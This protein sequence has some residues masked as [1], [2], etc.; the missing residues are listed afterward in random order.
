[1]GK[2]AK[3]IAIVGISRPARPRLIGVIRPPFL[4][5]DVGY[6]P[7]GARVWVTSG[8]RRMI[9]I[10]D[11]H[12]TRHNRTQRGDAPPQ[13]EPILGG[14]AFVTSGDD[15]I[16]RIHALDGRLLRSAPVPVGSYNVDEGF[17]LV[18]TPS[19]SRGTLCTFSD[20]GAA[21]EQSHVARSSHDA[22]FVMIA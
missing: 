7:R 10:Y 14:R 1:L 4:A 2:T 9:A 20:R 11:D 15:A 12:G 21:I 3:E 6:E 8:D 17:G 16:L 13:H 5:H 22:C 18:F 19:L